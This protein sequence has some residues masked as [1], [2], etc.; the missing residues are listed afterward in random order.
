MS[1]ASASVDTELRDLRLFGNSFKINSR[2]V[3]PRLESLTMD[4]DSLD[5]LLPRLRPASLPALRNFAIPYST[6]TRRGR[7]SELL[8]DTS[9][10]HLVDQVN[11]LFIDSRLIESSALNNFQPLFHKTLVSVDRDDHTFCCRLSPRLQHARIRSFDHFVLFARIIYRHEINPIDLPLRSLYFDAGDRHKTIPVTQRGMVRKYTVNELF[12]GVDI[13]YEER[14]EDRPFESIVS[15]EFV[16]R[17]SRR[18]AG[19]ESK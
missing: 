9:F 17:Q 1:D 6:K 5:T 7:L 14:G 8:K 3:L 10:R 4:L 18:N 15:E 19:E 11:A 16:V 2:F 13:V 12:P